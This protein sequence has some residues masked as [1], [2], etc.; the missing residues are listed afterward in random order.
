MLL[1]K[2]Y[3]CYNIKGGD[4]MLKKIF[5]FKRCDLRF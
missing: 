2:R 5:V 3:D 4:N 1:C